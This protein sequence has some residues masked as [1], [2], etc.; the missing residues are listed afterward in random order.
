MLLIVTDDD[1]LLLHLRDDEPGILHPGCWAGFGGALEDGESTLDALHRE[2][3]EEI[4]VEVIDPEFL[5]EVVDTE[6]AEDDVSLFFVRGGIAPEDID[7]Q[8]G[9]AVG[10]HS[11]DAIADLKMTPFVR[12]AIQ[13]H[14]EPRIRGHRRR[15]S[16]LAFERS[17]PTKRMAA[18]LLVR[19]D[20]GRVLLVEPTYKP[21][22]EIP[23][24]AIEAD[25]SP[26][27]CV[28]RET[29]E[30][31]GLVLP[32]GCLL[33]VDHQAAQP[34]R[35][36]SVQF[37]FDGGVMREASSRR[38]TLPADELRSWRFAN[39]EALGELASPPMARRLRHAIAVAD[40][41]TDDLYLEDGYPPGP[42][43]DD[44]S[45]T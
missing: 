14:L 17:L 37:V 15:P 4:G 44:P 29:R 43:S 3:R 9:A 11:F 22:W 24:G 2:V 5:V 40:G 20:H 18:G 1:R 28:L 33:V 34:E 27:A 41:G 8:E 45:S 12:R 19:D 7:L 16:S 32:P 13:R 31:L 6:G 10:V 35:T 39:P 25:E 23:G 21:D 26:R 38:I 42:G 30:E 36:E